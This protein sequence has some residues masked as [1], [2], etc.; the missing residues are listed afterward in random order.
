MPNNRTDFCVMASGGFSVSLTEPEHSVH[1]LY[2]LGLINSKLIFWN[3][4][5]ISNRFRGGWIT[6]TKQYFG[7][8]PIRT[9]DLSDPEDV[10][11]HD[12]MVELVQRML[13]L[14]ERLAAA[15][16]SQ[17]KTVIQ[18]QINAT[19]RQMDRLVYELYGLTEDE[20]EIVEV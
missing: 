14:H 11:H 3:L 6:C 13:S 17:E 12:R 16:L 9:V 7:T 10:A 18:H 1:P 20:I 4:N 5:L 19:N 2:L 8:L 15:R